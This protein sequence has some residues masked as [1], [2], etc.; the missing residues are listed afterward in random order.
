MR[1]DAYLFAAGKAKS[2][3][4]A[5]AMIEE[6]R[7]YF[8]N[9]LVKKSSFDIPE[10]QDSLL[11]IRSGGCPYVSRGGLKLEA[12]LNAFSLDV[13]GVCALDVGASTGGFTDCLLQKGARKVYAVDS[14]KAQ[15]DST[16]AEDSRVILRESCNARYLSPDDFEDSID[17]IVMDVSFIS[18]I[19]LYPALSS[20]VKAGAHMVTLVKPQFEVG[21]SGVGRGGIVKSEALRQEALKNVCRAAEDYGFEVVATITS[22][23]RGGDGNVEFL[24]CFRKECQ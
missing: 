16:L 11:E 8:H 3:T 24:A 21:R 6:G 23:I 22:P 13:Y 2:R 10:G 17:L 4:A 18:Q 20:L 14:G 1:I 15:L 5:Q 19:L 12:A 9:Q 7:V